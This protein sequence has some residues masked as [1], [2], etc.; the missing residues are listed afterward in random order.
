MIGGKT[1][2]FDLVFVL[3]CVAIALFVLSAAL[4]PLKRWARGWML[5]LGLAALAGAVLVQWKF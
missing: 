3:L 2:T 4:G 5:S 1:V